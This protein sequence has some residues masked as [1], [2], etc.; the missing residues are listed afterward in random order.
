MIAIYEFIYSAIFFIALL[1]PVSRLRNSDK[2]LY[3]VVLSVL[4][5]Y[6]VFRDGNYF[7]DYGSYVS[8][9][10]ENLAIGEPLYLL[11]IWIVKVFFSGQPLVLFFIFGLLSLL[12]KGIAIP[13]LTYLPFLSLLIFVSDFFLLHELTQ[14]RTGLAT[15]FLLLSLPALYE[16][17]AKTFFLFATLAALSHL[18]ALL[19]FPLWFCK[20]RTINSLFW[21]VLFSICF[22]LAII[23][24]DFVVILSFIPFAPIQDKL[25]LYTALQEE[26]DYQANIFSLLFL[27]K[28]AIALFLLWKIR[29]LKSKNKYSIIL[30]KIM[31]I[32]LCSL[33]LFSQNMAAGLRI[34]E[35]FGVVSIILFP[36][37][38]YLF[39][40]KIIGQVIIAVIALSLLYIRIYS[41]QLILDL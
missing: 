5:L 9:L 39:K 32:S 6:I 16:K 29:Y 33:L 20:S 27:A 41:Q 18:S 34:S 31:F 1:R 26:N 14:I 11:I 22:L 13:K 38:Y 2:T 12:L 28:S 30:L 25:M 40:T 36:F 4:L 24:I 8:T 17:N 23:K 15:G 37:I 21:V 19:M 3:A 10:K 7:L 35:F